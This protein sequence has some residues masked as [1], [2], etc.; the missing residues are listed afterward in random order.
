MLVLCALAGLGAGHAAR[1]VSVRRWPAPRAG[2]ARGSHRRRA[3]SRGSANAGPARA[4]AGGARPG[5]PRLWR[6]LRV[7]LRT[8]PAPRGRRS[9]SHHRRSAHAGAVP[10][11]RDGSARPQPPDAALLRHRARDGSG[12]SPAR[13]AAVVAPDPPLDPR[14]HRPAPPAG[15]GRA[16]RGAP[17]RRAAA[18][19]AHPAR[20][21]PP[22]GR[23]SRAGDLRLQRRAGRG[24][25]VPALPTRAPPRAARRWPGARDPRRVR[26]RR[27]RPALGAPRHRHGRPLP[28]R[29]PPR[30]REPRVEQSRG[31]A[32]RAARPRPGEPR[33]A[34]APALLRG[35]RRAPSS[36]A[37]DPRATRAVVSGADRERPLRV[38]G[39]AAW[40]DAGDAPPLRPA[41]AARR[42][43]QPPGRPARRAPHD[44]RGADPG[45]GRR[46]RASRPPAV[47][48]PLA[49]SRAPPPGRARRRR[50]ARR[51]RLP[52][53]A[54][55]RGGG[56]DRAGARPL[57]LGP[58]PVGDRGPGRAGRRRHGPHH[59][60]GVAGGPRSRRRP[61]CG[62][63]RGDPR[64][65]AGGR[66]TPRRHGWRR[67]RARRSGR[68]RRRPRAAAPRDPA[69]RGPRSHR[70]RAG[71]RG[72]PDGIARR[73]ADRR[74]VD[75]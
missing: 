35:N 41:L 56:G 44:G 5:A 20:G 30:A 6:A 39:S 21:L 57:A 16:P 48:E 27:G 19:P 63:G 37:V 46:Q 50:A 45:G 25:R 14:G 53:A 59:L 75:P 70:R 26:R 36:R 29:G 58:R 67:A 64:A 3:G 24:L 51:D 72:R 60:G 15:L 18:A 65:S 38:G 11:P 34:G 43:R 62:T 9:R 74:G 28:R 10:E 55:H 1:S 69:P 49:P 2:S 8:R 54:A 42:G 73:R 22:R 33:R 61:R 71:S 40:G 52:G 47:P 68:A 13:P 12:R 17:D 66:D 23:L 31:G 32:A 4:P 7:L